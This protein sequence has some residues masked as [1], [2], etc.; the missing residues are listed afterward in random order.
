MPE[1]FMSW[2]FWYAVG[3]AIVVIAAVL[4]IV[5]L[6]TARGIEEEASRALEAA[7]RVEENT[8]AVPALSGARDTLERIRAHVDGIREKTGTLAGAVGGGQGTAEEAPKE[9]ER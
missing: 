5:I 7:R 1:L 9:W 2:G 4:L 8:S 3:G 6:L